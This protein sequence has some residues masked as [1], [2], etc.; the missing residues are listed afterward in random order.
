MQKLGTKRTA[1]IYLSKQNNTEKEIEVKYFL[2]SI[3]YVR[4]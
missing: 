3:L 2:H 1:K 4:G